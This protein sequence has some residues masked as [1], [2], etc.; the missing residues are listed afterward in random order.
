MNGVTSGM[1][2]MKTTNNFNYIITIINKH[3]EKS[4]SIT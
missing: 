2:A 1:M 3:Y 4:I